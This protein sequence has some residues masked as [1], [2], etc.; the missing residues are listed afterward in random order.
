ML[1]KQPGATSGQALEGRTLSVRHTRSRDMTGAF[2]PVWFDA[3]ATHW[4]HR[5]RFGC[6]CEYR[7]T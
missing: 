2:S 7:D 4:Q 1:S 3:E 5:T 6:G